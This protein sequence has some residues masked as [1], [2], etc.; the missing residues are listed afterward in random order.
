MKRNTL[1]LRKRPLKLN[2]TT[3]RNLTTVDAA[4]LKAVAGG[5]IGRSN[6][7]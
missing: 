2:T 6:R 3:I 5:V 1:K 4:R 7:Y